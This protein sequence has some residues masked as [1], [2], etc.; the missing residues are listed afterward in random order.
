[1]SME[2]PA[3]PISRFLK[4][5]ASAQGAGS[6]LDAVAPVVEWW[7]ANAP[8]GLRTA[9]SFMF[10]V[11]LPDHQGATERWASGLPEEGIVRNMGKQTPA[12]PH[13]EGRRSEERRVGKGCVST[14][15]SRWSPYH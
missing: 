1:M 3:I 2:I 10:Y 15:R 8:A 6:D 11:S 4:A 5:M 14:C 12:E 7:N 9:S 13:L